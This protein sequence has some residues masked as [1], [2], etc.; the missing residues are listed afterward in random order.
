MS[1]EGGD[2]CVVVSSTNMLPADGRSL[3][4]A[5]GADAPT[6]WGTNAEGCSGV[7]SDLALSLPATTVLFSFSFYFKHCH[8]IAVPL[9]FVHL[10][11]CIYVSIYIY[12]YIYRERRVQRE[13]W[14]QHWELWEWFVVLYLFLLQKRQGHLQ[15]STIQ[16]TRK[17]TPPLPK[18]PN[19]MD[20]LVL[21]FVCIRKTHQNYSSSF[22][23]FFLCQQKTRIEGLTFL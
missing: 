14:C 23:G 12:I 4:E 8:Q 5:P 19:H 2:W 15:N 7:P 13:W 20:I 10:S 1:E 17:I 6:L 18:P 11:E 3:Q 21:F 22:W 9:L 16:T